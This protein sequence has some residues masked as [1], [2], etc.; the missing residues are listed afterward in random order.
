MSRNFEVLGKAAPEI[1]LA[2]RP[3]KPLMA[4]PVSSSGEYGELIGRLF[5]SPAAVAIIGGHRAANES[6]RAERVAGIVGDLA[7][8]LA[9]TGK[10]I[11]IVDVRALFRLNPIAAPNETD[12]VSGDTPNVWLWPAPGSQKIEFFKSRE[13]PGV[14]NWL[15]SL[16]RR[17][18]CVLLDC[19]AVEG[20]PGVAEVAAMADASV[21]VVEAGTTPKQ[22]IQQEQR[23]L[24]LK[25]A[26]VAGCILVRRR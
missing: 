3:G 24:Q 12:F 21:L 25:G 5:S 13:A 9:V 22:Q 26:K 1:S 18:D 17:F 16:R 10:R 6:G 20:E 23:A 15:D 8:E 7:R 19:P 2:S 4:E 14:G 11:I